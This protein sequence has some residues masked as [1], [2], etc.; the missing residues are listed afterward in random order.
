M[1]TFTTSQVCDAYGFHPNT[2]RDW[3]GWVPGAL[4]LDGNQPDRTGWRRFSIADAVRLQM[5]SKLVNIYYMEPFIAAQFLN[6]GFA[7]ISEGVSVCLKRLADAPNAY[8]IPEYWI[9]FNRVDD[10]LHRLCEA[11]SSRQELQNANSVYLGGAILFDLHS[12]LLTAS[13]KLSNVIKRDA[14]AVPTIKE[15]AGDA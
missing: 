9:A 15:A 5:L 3:M 4:K 1:T 14:S 10:D 2:L 8:P 13:I 12:E 7:K 6:E 11:F